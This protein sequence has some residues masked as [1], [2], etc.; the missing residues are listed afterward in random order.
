MGHQT[1]LL[2][3]RRPPQAREAQVG[4]SD[5]EAQGVAERGVAAVMGAPAAMA[6]WV[7]M[8]GWVAAA[9]PRPLPRGH[10]PTGGLRVRQWCRRP[11]PI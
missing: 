5:E 10:A 2:P 4:P 11:G 7:V 9:S 8:A 1:G 3:G 6:G